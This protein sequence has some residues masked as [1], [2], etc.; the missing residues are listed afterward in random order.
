MNETL[1]FPSKTTTSVSILPTSSLLYYQLA[2]NFIS[3]EEKQDYFQ[4]HVHQ[5][6]NAITKSRRALQKSL[7]LARLVSKKYARLKK[8]VPYR[9]NGNAFWIEMHLDPRLN[10]TFKNCP[11]HTVEC[12]YCCDKQKDLILD[13]EKIKL[14]PTKIE[15]NR[16]LHRVHGRRIIKLSIARKKY[17]NRLENIHHAV[18]H[19]KQRIKVTNLDLERLSLQMDQV[20]K[21]TYNT[22]T[23][24]MT[25][26]QQ[27]DIKRESLLFKTSSV[28]AFGQELEIDQAKPT[29]NLEIER[30][31]IILTEKSVELNYL[32]HQH[33]LILHS[34][35]KI[36][37]WFKF[38]L[39]IQAGRRARKAFCERII[40]IKKSE[41]LI[42]YHLFRRL[43]AS[44]IQRGWRC[45]CARSCLFR[46][47][48]M[49]AIQM[50][51]RLQ[52]WWRLL[53]I[54]KRN[55]LLLKMFNFIMKC[56]CQ[57][58]KTGWKLWWKV[59]EKMRRIEWLRRHIRKCKYH[60][61]MITLQK[62]IRYYLSIGRKSF[63]KK[64]KSKLH[65]S[66]HKKFTVK[67]YSL[68]RWTFQACLFDLEKLQNRTKRLLN[69]AE[70]YFKFSNENNNKNNSRQ[71]NTKRKTD[72]IYRTFAKGT[73]TIPAYY[74]ERYRGIGTR[75]DVKWSKYGESYEWLLLQSVDRRFRACQAGK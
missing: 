8:V 13:A 23:N 5:L 31:T 7:T 29:L 11:D 70:I 15:Q 4:S 18:Q 69:H 14:H 3:T 22:E 59:I 10:Q 74:L 73:L 56:V 62:K 67:N 50:I 68:D 20:E 65:F 64:V 19:S 6:R 28:H 24:F 42:L 66:I 71:T 43:A 1:T 53:L 35:A 36:A 58:M 75:H 39:R 51:R 41:D 45:C 37:S 33:P 32:N 30:A 55:R 63:I 46:L 48:N 47:R 2:P 34:F 60:M 26:R 38:R 21:G 40:K 72:S 25:K 16:Y 52:K 12:S 44:I 49:K 54:K 9:S 57:K 27:N 61:S 17:K